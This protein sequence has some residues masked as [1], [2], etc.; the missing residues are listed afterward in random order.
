MI[1]RHVAYPVWIAAMLLLSATF[2]VGMESVAQPNTARG[3]KQSTAP[4]IPYVSAACDA[5]DALALIGKDGMMQKAP[6]HAAM[7][8]QARIATCKQIIEKYIDGL[9]PEAPS[10]ANFPAGM[11]ALPTPTP[12]LKVPPGCSTSVNGGGAPSYD[13]PQLYSALTFCTSWISRYIPSPTPA[14]PQPIALHSR[15]TQSGETW[16]KIIYVMATASDPSMSAQVAL[17]FA[18]DLRSIRLQ[19]SPPSGGAVAQ[20]RDVYTGSPVKYIIMAEP[21]WTVQQYQQQCYS[22]PSTAGAI[23]AVQPGTQSSSFNLLYSTSWTALSLQA[24][25]VDCEP[26]NTAYTNGASYIVHLSHV[27]TGTGKRVSFSL[28]TALGL[29]AGI[30]AVHPTHSSTY[31]VVAPSPLPSPGGSYQTGYSVGTNQGLGAAAAAG[32]AALTPLA[33][34]NFGQGANV[35]AQVAG[36]MAKALPELIDDLMT[37]C[38]YNDDEPNSSIPMPQCQWFSYRPATQALP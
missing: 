30:L 3:H 18:N 34:T 12:R 15:G 9:P 16:T 10:I 35:D 29:L 8:F 13:L 38:N 4:I 7:M 14:T 28:S 1:A 19:P 2:V 20:L 23:I 27:R 21:T 17:Q 25:I 37:P 5:S 31:A 24:M 22:D 26:T 32:V 36:G 6:R 33:S 11:A